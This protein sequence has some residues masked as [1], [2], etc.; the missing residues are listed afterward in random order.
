LELVV[1]AEH[2]QPIRLVVAI[3]YLVQ[4]LHLVVV[5]V[6]T[7][8]LEMITAQLVALVVVAVVLQEEVLTVYPLKVMLAET[9]IYLQHLPML[10]AVEVG[11]VQ[12]VGMQLLL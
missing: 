3:L 4:S 10:L 1:L 12:M 7:N 8:T 5:E 2:L 6:V 11:L 9:V